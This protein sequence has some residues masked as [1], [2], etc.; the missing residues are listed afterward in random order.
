MQIDLFKDLTITRDSN[1]LLAQVEKR[2]FAL[3]VPE[4]KM[5]EVLQSDKDFK[6]NILEKLN[7]GRIYK[8][9]YS[10]SVDSLFTLEAMGLGTDT[11][12]YTVIL[13]L[14]DKLDYVLHRLTGCPTSVIRKLPNYPS[15]SRNIMNLNYSNLT[16]IKIG[17]FMK[18]GDEV[19]SWFSGML[20]DIV[21][22]G[23]LTD[24]EAI[25]N[26]IL[27]LY[28]NIVAEV[29]HLKV[30]IIMALRQQYSPD[31]VIRSK[32]VSSIIATTDSQI[33]T[34]LVLIDDNYETCEIKLLLLQKFE[35]FTRGIY[36]VFNRTN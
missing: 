27:E 11:K 35:Y 18:L 3:N 24:E 28:N 16:D 31:F 6:T 29:D 1:R 9:A 21:N 22:S 32:S 17:D 30:Y 34:D 14:S 19:C 2:K 26:F 20:Y 4:S 7:E 25:D 15:V 10:V 12:K 33:D 23:D 8:R 36:N 13:D 5:C